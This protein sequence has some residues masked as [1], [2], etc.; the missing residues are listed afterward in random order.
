MRQFGPLH[1]QN[2]CQSIRKSFHLLAGHVNGHRL[3]G[4]GALLEGAPTRGVSAACSGRLMQFE[5]PDIYQQLR[6][7]NDPSEF[8]AL[9]FGVLGLDAKHRVTTYNAFE[10]KLSGL[11][12]ERVIGRHVFSEVA[13]CTNN[14]M[15]A[16]RFEN[17][18]SLD[19]TIDYV[20]T[21]RMRP[22]PVRLRMLRQP[23]GAQQ[24]L[25]VERA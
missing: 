20:F 8:D 23:D 13:P 14:F 19:A 10:S 9:D 11:S 7:L 6:A 16:Q 18:E 24:F 4:R 12:P 15:V 2:K 5:A 1:L 17:E 22:T 21:L 25:L 3:D